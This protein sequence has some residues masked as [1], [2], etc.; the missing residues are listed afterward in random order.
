MLYDVVCVFLHPSRLASCV[1]PTRKVCVGCQKV[2]AFSCIAL[3]LYILT[4]YSPVRRVLI[5]YYTPIFSHP[6]HQHIFSHLTHLRDEFSHPTTH[7]Y[8]HALHT[9]VY[10]HIPHTCTTY[11]HTLLHT[12]I[13]TPYTPAYIPTPH[14]PARRILT[15][16]S[17]PKS[18]HPTHRRIFSHPTHLHDSPEFLERFQLAGKKGEEGGAGGRESLLRALG[19]LLVLQPGC[20]GEEGGDWEGGQEEAGKILSGEHTRPSLVCH[21]SRGVSMAV[22]QRLLTMHYGALPT[23]DPI[24]ELHGGKGRGWE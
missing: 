16:Y 6:T 12:H 18:S 14:T 2:V 1:H 19:V 8:S 7:Q 5:P 21:G 20:R 10:S 9:S 17:T 22:F 24:G 13:L 4:P 15:C 11:S 3:Y 23:A